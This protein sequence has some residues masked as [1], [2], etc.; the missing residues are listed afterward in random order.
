LVGTGVDVTIPGGGG[1]GASY[2]NTLFVDP[3][4]N[5]AAAAAAA[6]VGTGGRID[7]P[8]AQVSGALDWLW[9]HDQSDWTIWVF[10]GRYT[11]VSNWYFRTSTT[12]VGNVYGTTIKLNGNCDIIF[13][14]FTAQSSIKMWQAGWFS[15]I[16]DAPMRSSSPGSGVQKHGGARIIT[17]HNNSNNTWPAPQIYLGDGDFWLGGTSDG[18]QVEISVKLHNVEF[19]ND[20]NAGGSNGNAG[21]NIVLGRHG[22]LQF[23]IDNCKFIT[24]DAVNIL[25]QP[26]YNGSGGSTTLAPNKL[27][28]YFTNTTWYTKEAT[29]AYP[30]W[31]LSRFRNV[32]YKQKVLVHNSKF[33]TMGVGWYNGDSSGNS[34]HILTNAYSIKSHWIMSWSN[35]VFYAPQQQIGNG[36]GSPGNSTWYMWDE[37]DPWPIANELDLLG[38]SI[39]DNQIVGYAGGFGN[40]VFIDTMGN[41]TVALY[42][43]NLAGSIMDYSEQT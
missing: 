32:S 14:G 37:M 1:G 33:I 36:T 18:S 22:E 7:I 29:Y 16:G 4:G 9:Q 40:P 43:N 31:E 27:N 5:D 38:S 25:G 15:I 19:Q 13:T 6:A 11:E 35:N 20:G 12:G 3:G 26:N 17:N 42:G 28:W 2:L 24:K 8:F 30:N 39:S 10:P 41:M 34:G 23:E 21:I